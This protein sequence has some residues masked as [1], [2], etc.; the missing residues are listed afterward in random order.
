[1]DCSTPGF[2]P[3]GL[4]HARLPCPSPSSRVCSNSCSLS[5]WCYLTIHDKLA[6]LS[7]TW[8]AAITSKCPPRLCL[9]L[10][11]EQVKLF[12]QEFLMASNCLLNQ[13]QIL[14]LGFRSPW[15][16]SSLF[17][18]FFSPSISYNLCCHQ[19]SQCFLNSTLL[20]TLYSINLD[21]L[22]SLFV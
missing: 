6:L 11:K 22:M 16:S 15:P 4:Q 13:I 19:I 8:S 3:H 17:F 20:L 2:W 14:N 7:F 1:M 12:P 18:Q 9:W 10:S 5:R 21:A